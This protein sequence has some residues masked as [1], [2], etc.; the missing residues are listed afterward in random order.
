MISVYIL[1]I[2]GIV[3]ILQGMYEPLTQLFYLDP[4][5]ALSEPWLFFT[6]MFLHGGIKH[7][8]FNGYALFLFGT[9]LES[10]ISKR[11]FLIVYL[12]AGLIGGLV[13]YLTYVLGIIESVP[14]LGASAAI[15][16]VLGA[17]AMLLP[18][19]RIFLWFFPMRMREAV[20]FWVI[21]EFLGTFDTNSGIAS[22][23]HLGGL[24]FGLFYAYFFLKQRGIK[25]KPMVQ[26]SYQLKAEDK[27]FSYLSH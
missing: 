27:I 20:V 18:N 21:I 6:S 22:A 17:V 10:R 26:A 8:F 7:L 2:L 16:G 5:R 13:Y 9:I 14:A 3:F 19:L 15:Y 23:G 4:S 24:I 12:G 25:E 11:E 1:A